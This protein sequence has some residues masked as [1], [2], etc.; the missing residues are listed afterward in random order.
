MRRTAHFVKV[1]FNFNVSRFILSAIL[2][3]LPFHVLR[4]LWLAEA[5]WRY[6]VRIG[7]IHP[8]KSTRAYRFLGWVGKPARSGRAN[9]VAVREMHIVWRHVVKAGRGNRSNPQLYFELARWCLQVKK[10]PVRSLRGYYQNTQLF[11]I[12]LRHG[13]L[14]SSTVWWDALSS[15]DKNLLEKRLHQLWPVVK[16]IVLA[17]QATTSK[18][19]TGNP[20]KSKNKRSRIP[21]PSPGSAWRLAISNLCQP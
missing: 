2:E 14:T 8:K 10:I 20:V 5:H 12:L 15:H 17:L 11:D 18:L 13:Q 6:L 19:R 4:D 21:L 9:P 1:V 7:I 16:L 3:P